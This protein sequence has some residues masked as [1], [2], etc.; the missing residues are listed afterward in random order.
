VRAT[1]RGFEVDPNTVLQ[2]WLEAAEHLQALTHFFLCDVH[3]K[4]RQLDELYAVIRAL[5]TG[6]SSAGDAIACLEPGRPWVWTAID[7]GSTWLLAMEVGPRTV[8]LAQRVVHRVDQR[9]AS[10][11]GPAWFSDGFKG[12][13]PAIVG[14][15]AGGGNRSAA[16]PWPPAR[17]AA[18]GLVCS[19]R[20]RQAVPASAHG[21]CNTG[22]CSARWGRSHRSYRCVAGRST[23]HLGTLLDI[24]SAWRR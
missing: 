5:T 21:E 9:R 4:Q 23:R 11:C 10:G 16:R 24:A 6:Q 22:W 7:P 13:L 20:S 19:M 18:A 14:H 15:F 8:A 1:A 17:H 2:W 3:S 12:Y